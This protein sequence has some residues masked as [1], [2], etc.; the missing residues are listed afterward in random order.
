MLAWLNRLPVKGI[1]SHPQ[2]TAKSFSSR[3]EIQSKTAAP[4][5]TADGKDSP[6]TE[7]KS[8]LNRLLDQFNG[9]FSS[10]SKTHADGKHMFILPEQ[11]NWKERV[12]TY[13]ESPFEKELFS[14]KKKNNELVVTKEWIKGIKSN[15]NLTRD[16]A[17]TLFKAYL[18]YT[19]KANIVELSPHSQL[20]LIMFA[21]HLNEGANAK[22]LLYE[23]VLSLPLSQFME[24]ADALNKDFTSFPAIAQA[25]I[26]KQLSNRRKKM[27]KEQGLEEEQVKAFNKLFKTLVITFYTTH[28]DLSDNI[29]QQ[30]DKLRLG[31]MK[32][33][34]IETAYKKSL[35]EIEQRYRLKL[36]QLKRHR[37]Q[38][39]SE[40]EEERQRRI[41]LL[42]E[43]LESDL[44]AGLKN[45]VIE[46]DQL[47]QQCKSVTS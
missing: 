40:A 15:T 13:A 3:P 39:I 34:P 31:C 22:A 5:K 44:I 24:F 29:F 38:K 20:K 7:K 18:T 23:A 12:E 26:L 45:L 37:T 43:N 27:A 28:E 6:V 9:I 4:F 11:K 21:S 14:L 1:S 33:Q 36:R 35:E 47:E 10:V 30:Q 42:Y 46:P 8:F 32:I 41:E 2:D 16:A 19:D 17:L 25:L